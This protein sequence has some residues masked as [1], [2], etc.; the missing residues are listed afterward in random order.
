MAETY[1]LIRTEELSG[2]SS[3]MRRSQRTTSCTLIGSKLVSVP[4]SHSSMMVLMGWDGV[5][6]DLR[7]TLMI[8]NIPNRMTDD[9][10]MSFI[11][12][13]SPISHTR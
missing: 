12:E 8:K 13:V 1:D 11:E 2:V 10:L 7:T 5:G 6:L 9:V 4:L 3:E